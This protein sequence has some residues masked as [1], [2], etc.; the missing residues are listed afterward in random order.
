MKYSDLKLALSSEELS[1]LVLLLI[2]LDRSS[3][4]FD[5]KFCVNELCFSSEYFEFLISSK[6]KFL[7]ALS[8]ANQLNNERKEK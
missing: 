2:D 8:L 4:F 7:S 3:V 1:A 5:G 6:H